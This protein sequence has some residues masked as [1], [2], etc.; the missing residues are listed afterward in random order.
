MSWQYDFAVIEIKPQSQ[1]LVLPLGDSKNLNPGDSM[2]I[3][4]YHGGLDESV[5]EPQWTKGYLIEHNKN[6]LPM[7]LR[8]TAN[9]GSSG[10]PV[11]STDKKFVIGLVFAGPI[12][13][14]TRGRIT[15]AIPM[16]NIKK[17]SSI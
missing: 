11:I 12:D 1:N 3:I 8:V 6:S 17:L 16:E 15:Y 10:S 14:T 2:L 7:T 13:R 5:S 4:G 9:P